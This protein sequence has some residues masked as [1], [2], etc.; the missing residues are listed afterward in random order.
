MSSRPTQQFVKG[1]TIVQEGSRGDRSFKIIRGEVVICKK[2]G[3]GNLVPIAKLG[4]GEIFGEM[5]LFEDE[6]LR[7]AT[8]IAV[9]SEVMV[10]IY[11]QDEFQQMFQTLNPSTRNIFEGM[12]KRLR[13]TSDSFTEMVEP[14]KAASQLPDGS[15]RE[16]AFIK[17]S[18]LNN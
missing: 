3:S 12:S 16:S 15:I 4:N 7:T 2:S 17:R 18:N 8:A 6:N 11:Y 9:S 10:E 5:Y 1:Q 14:K 13:K